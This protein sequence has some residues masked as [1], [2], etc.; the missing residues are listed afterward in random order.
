M[1]RPSFCFCEEATNVIINDTLW[2]EIEPWMIELRR[3]I[4]RHP[5]LGLDTPETQKLIEDAL[6]SLGIQ[7]T[8]PILHGVKAVIGSEKAGEAIL[9]RAD[10]DALPI[11]ENND[12]PFRSEIPG[13]MHACG[14]DCHTAMLLGAARYLKAHEAELPRPV[15]LMF[16]PAEEGPGGALPMIEA[17]VLNDPPVKEA[18]MV[19][20]SSDLPYGVIGLREG[21]AMGACDDFTLSILGRGGH[22]S[23]PHVGVDAIYVASAVIQAVQGIVSREQ[24]SFDPLVISFGTIH[25]GYRENVIADRVD[26]TGTIRTMTP[27]TRE[28][29]VRRFRE[30]VESVT[31]TYGAKAELVMDPGYPP[32]VADISWSRRVESVLQSELGGDAVRQID[33]T[34]GVEDF[35][36]VAERVPGVCLNV[37]IVGDQFTTGL[38]SAGLIVDERGLRAGAAGFASLALRS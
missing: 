4:H 33:P 5:E 3:R 8:R 30:V 19:H 16:Q 10:M 31:G 38:H 17:G 36:Y 2:E 32:L 25:G 35:A 26:L 27:A 34:L 6:D 22:G 1:W 23:T 20:V 37:G 29:A 15:V 9:L 11:L 28:R 21:P 7:H 24:D 18:A 14:H 12:L 13:R